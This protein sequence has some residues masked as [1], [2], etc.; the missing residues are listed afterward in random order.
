[1]ITYPTVQLAYSNRVYVSQA[2][3]LVGGV[4]SAKPAGFW[5]R[6]WRQCLRDSCSERGVR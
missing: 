1:M 2:A 6:R 5:S 4:Y 3:V